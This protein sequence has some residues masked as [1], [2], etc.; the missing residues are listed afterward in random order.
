MKKLN[1]G[2][3]GAAGLAAGKLVQLLLM[4]ESVQIVLLTDIKEL[5]GRSIQSFHP[6]LR[7]RLPLKISSYDPRK[8]KKMCDV[9][10]FA[11]PHGFSMRHVDELLKGRLKVID[12]SGDFRLKDPRVFAQWYGMAHE[13]SRALQEAVYGLPEF[14]AKEIKRARLISNPGCYPTSV[15]LGAAPLLKK[16]LALPRIIAHSVSGVSGAGRSRPQDFQLVDMD[17]NIRPYKVGTH[18]H[19]P[20]MEQELSCISKKS[21][22]VLFAPHVGGYRCGIISTLYLAPRAKLLSTEGIIDVYRKTYAGKPFVRIYEPGKLPQVSDAVGTNFC[23]IGATYDERTHTYIITAV[24]DNL[25][26]GAGGQAI[27]NMNIAC[28]FPETLGLI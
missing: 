8:I 25:I 3:V 28:R 16:G 1:V 2:V 13:N 6:I 4:H 9:V 18:Q 15:I 7:A 19:T 22:T 12:L 5:E 23:D 17:E 10:F 26:K 20:E 11:T 21:V 14:H 27:Q 24:I